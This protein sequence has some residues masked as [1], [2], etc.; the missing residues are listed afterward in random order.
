MQKSN[1]FERIASGLD[2]FQEA[3]FWLHMMEDHYHYSNPFRW[4]LN[5]FIKALK[6]T[7]QLIQMALQIQ[8]GFKTWFVPL[9][10]ELGSDPLI[11]FLGK[12]RDIVVHK[13]MLIPRSGG[14]VGITEMRGM[15]FGLTFPIHPLENSDDAMKRYLQHAR[16]NRD[17]LG[18]LEPDEESAPCIRREWK[19]EGF[20]EEVGDLCAKAWLRLGD[21][22]AAVLKWLGEDV[23]PLSLDCRHGTQRVQFRIYDRDQLSQQM[24][25]L[26]P[27]PSKD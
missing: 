21:L 10:D 19:L 3:H 26:P 15:K 9:R 25:E 18:I 13:E 8:E 20:D 6:E 23:R 5:V 14:Y 7:P 12:Q 24:R 4:Y 16:D 17:F 27:T 22:I 2:R 11:G 1:A